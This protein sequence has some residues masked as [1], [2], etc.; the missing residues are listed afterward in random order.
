MFIRNKGLV[1][2]YVHKPA[3]CDASRVGVDEC[4]RVCKAQEVAVHRWIPASERDNTE[5]LPNV[6]MSKD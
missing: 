5:S 6:P 1:L 3:S 4:L 2:C